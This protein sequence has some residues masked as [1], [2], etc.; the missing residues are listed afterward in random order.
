MVKYKFILKREVGIVENNLSKELNELKKL[1]VTQN[2][3]DEIPK[4]DF[5]A[6]I[7]VKDKFKFE[8]KSREKGHNYPHFHVKAGD[9]NGSYRIDPIE[10]IVS[11]F[12]RKDDDLIIEWGKKHKKKLIETWNKFHCDNKIEV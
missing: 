10:K 8:I 3:W 2:E 7:D 11:N 1:L 9:K 5:S 6:N 12:T 4:S